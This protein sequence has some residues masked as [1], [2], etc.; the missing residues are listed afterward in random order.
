M[1]W[2][3]KYFEG[4]IF[5]SLSANNHLFRFKKIFKKKEQIYNFKFISQ[6]NL[7]IYSKILMSHVRSFEKFIET[8]IIANI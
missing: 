3:I 4:G 1:P 5:F 7:I 8:E 6:A 2:T